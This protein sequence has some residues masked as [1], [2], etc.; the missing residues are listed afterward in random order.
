MYERMEGNGTSSD[1]PM[2]LARCLG[3]FSI[4][5][6]AVELLAPGRLARALGMEGREPLI[7]GF[8]AREMA[9][10]VALLSAANPT[11]WIWG[12]VAGDALDLLTLAGGLDAD[13]PK[14]KNVEI[15]MAAVAGVTAVDMVC[16][17]QL[18]AGVPDRV[19]RVHYE[20]S[21]Y[22]R[23]ISEAHGLS[24]RSDAEPEV[25]PAT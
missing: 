7:Q 19:E 25:A 5:L 10:G 24:V 16:G 11:P 23:P 4:G 22:L 2:R 8:G 1:A 3:W 18:A 14:K 20:R 13:N 21:G 12:R 9:T 17:Q 6:G 15:A